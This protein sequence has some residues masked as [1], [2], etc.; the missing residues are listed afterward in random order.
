[1]RKLVILLACLCAS[2]LALADIQTP[3]VRAVG[4]AKG[5]R[6]AVNEALVSALEQHDGVTMSA[7]ELQTM[8]HADTAT[9]IRENGVLDDKAKLEMNDSI[10]KE[11]QKWAKGRISGYTVL[12]DVFD[13]STQKY[14][15]EVEVRFPPKYV[16]PGRP[17]SNLRR[18][19]VTTFNVQGNSFNW[20]G[21]PVGTVEWSSALADQLKDRYFE[22]SYITSKAVIC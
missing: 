12:S 1:M 13:P 9:S 2:F 5:Y 17:E 22:R 8:S 16:G 3:A 21:Q 14:R 18:M 4:E 20:Y 19:A 10:N 7:T 6:S 11:M 15:V